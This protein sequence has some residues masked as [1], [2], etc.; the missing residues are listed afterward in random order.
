MAQRKNALNRNVDGSFFVDSS[1]IDCGTCCYL[2]PDHFASSGSNSFVYSQPTTQSDISNAL[3][4]LVDCPVSAIGAPNELTS[5]IP[6]NAFP[7][8]V[9]ENASGSVYY[10][11]WS[12]KRSYGASSWLILRSDGNVLIDSPRWS[13]TLAKQIKKMGGVKFMILT[14]SD[15]VADH[16]RW[17]N[18][19]N[20]E[21]WIHENDADSAPNAEKILHGM[22]CFSLEEGLI[23]IP[24]PG[25]TAGSVVVV[26]G[27]YEQVLFSGDHLWWNQEK[28]SLVASRNY[29][30][31]NWD[32]QIESIK[33]LDNLEVKWLLPGHGYSHKFK[34]GEW[35]VALAELI[36][37][38]S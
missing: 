7:L 21:R 20:C 31:W 4:A 10:C 3:L 14:H 2:A 19:L 12:S 6:N 17:S 16:E 25:H 27:D 8:W 36:N 1:C 11:G 28:E 26:L 30:W 9:T 23:I 15:D 38:L 35:K 5:Q 37:Y 32:E 33:K 34:L 29:C 18:A 13:S 24:T 22:D